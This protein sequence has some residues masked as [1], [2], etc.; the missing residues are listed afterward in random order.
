M[1]PFR[2]VVAVEIMYSVVEKFS[3]KIFIV[4]RYK[5]NFENLRIEN[6]PMKMFIVRKKKTYFRIS[7]KKITPSFD[8]SE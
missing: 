1:R 2:L 8:E 5:Q 7:G 6:L 4:K 3:V